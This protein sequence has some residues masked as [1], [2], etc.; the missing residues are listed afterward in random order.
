MEPIYRFAAR[1]TLGVLV[2]VPLVALDPPSRDDPPRKADTKQGT[3][4]RAGKDEKATPAKQPV[5]DSEADQEAKE[6]IDRQRSRR[7]ERD[8]EIDR[9]MNKKQ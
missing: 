7:K 6:R 4:P 8:R 1:F 9:R 5:K 3:A 2:A